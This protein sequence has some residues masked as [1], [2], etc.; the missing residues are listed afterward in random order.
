MSIL[1]GL[2]HVTTESDEKL[3]EKV[4]LLMR[5][6][7]QDE[8]H[9]IGTELNIEEIKSVSNY[10]DLE[11]YKAALAIARR[12]DDNT[13]LQ[14]LSNHP[15]RYITLGGFQGN[16]YTANERG[17]I[18]LVSSWEQV[19]KNVQ[20]ALEKDGDKAYG[21]LQA[22]INKKGRAAYFELID[23]IEKVLAY[24]FVPSYL[25][26]RLG[27]MKLVFK[28]GSNKYP[29]WTIPTEIIPVVA[30]ELQKFRNL[31]ITSKKSKRHAKT[32]SDKSEESELFL[33]ERRLDEL[34]GAVVERKREI[35]LIFENKFKTKFFN[36]NEKAMFSIK[37]PCSNEEDFN[38][39]IQGLCV[40]LDDI[41]SNE[42]KKLLNDTEETRGSL[43]LM[44]SFLNKHSKNFNKELIKAFRMI[45]VLRSKKFPV[46][47]D[48]GR[49]IEAMQ[50]FDQSNFPPDWQI[51]WEKV[52][53]R[54][55]K[56]LQSFR[57]AFQ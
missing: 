21:V 55:A 44:E 38:N 11:H 26:P 29:D 34:V 31:P 7:W 16:F 17:I 32:E 14:L 42:L 46:H 51:L 50:Y 30:E 4:L 24:E 5:L 43:D 10:W 8:L 48:D 56:S 39:R 33:I 27:P 22:L 28:T 2:F 12:L 57:D 47:H 9:K 23:E 53:E 25:L 20:K 6:Y 15:P 19:R 41:Q 36:D 3:K 52:L 35:N 13:L 37:K 40:V 18:S 45:R 49:F 54:C 1:L